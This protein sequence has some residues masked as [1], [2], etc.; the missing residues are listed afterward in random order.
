MSY[1]ATISNKADDEDGLTNAY[2]GTTTSIH[3]KGG[4]KDLKNHNQ[5]VFLCIYDL[6]NLSIYP[7]VHSK[8]ITQVGG[9]TEGS[10]LAYILHLT[11]HILLFSLT[12]SSSVSVCLC[13]W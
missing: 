5:S 13:I 7:D 3:K 6:K 9:H 4:I 12:L 8:K 10:P 11:L 1:L 2:N